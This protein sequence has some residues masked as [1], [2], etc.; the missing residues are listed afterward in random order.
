MSEAIDGI[1][2][3]GLMRRPELWPALAAKFA[4]ALE[5][6]EQ[7]LDERDVARNDARYRTEERDAEK[8]RADK[9]EDEVERL[10]EAAERAARVLGCPSRIADIPEEISVAK[11]ILD[12]ALAAKPQA[13]SA[14]EGEGGE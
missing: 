5:R 8:A 12:E 10:R 9:A 4:Q 11:A 13:P 7:A 14:A 2:Y 1:T 6:V 3:D